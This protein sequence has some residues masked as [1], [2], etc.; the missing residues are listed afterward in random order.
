VASAALGAPMLLAPRRLLRAAGIRSDG[1]AVAVLAAVGVREFAAT[2]T[3]LG[4]RHRRVGAWSRVV[5]D[6]IDLSLL[7]AAFRTRRADTPRLLGAIAFIATIL[8]ADLFT[9][10]RLNQAE[11]VGVRDG[12]ESHGMGAG[13]DTGGGPTRVRTAV[14]I[15]ASEEE[16]RTAFQEFDWS[17]FDPGTLLASGQARIVRAPGERGTELHLDYEPGVRGGRVAVPALKLAGRSPDQ[18]INDELRR[19]KA[20]IETGVEVR[21]D[22][23]PESYSARRQILQRPAQPRA[24][25]AESGQE[26]GQTA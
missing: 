8:A 11:G 24:G 5:G 25:G 10:L 12:S 3:I 26:V 20:L 7:G 2:A 13:H 22:K 17:E 9:A 16:V 19:F 6:T 15:L 14:T 23:T 4:M 21:S 18:T 1:K